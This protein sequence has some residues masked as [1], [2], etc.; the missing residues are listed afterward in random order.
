MFISDYYDLLTGERS[1]MVYEDAEK[2]YAEVRKEGKALLEDAFGALL[3]SSTRLSVSPDEPQAAAVS[4]RECNIVAFNTTMFP[5]LDVVTVPLTGNGG[6]KLKT[7]VIQTSAD[8]KFGYALMHGT[9]GFGL[10]RS[11]GLFADCDTPSGMPCERFYFKDEIDTHYSLY[12]L[13]CIQHTLATSY[14]VILLFN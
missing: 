2:L 8:G 9:D 10:A 4:S 13:K 7:K 12:Y 3:K 6:P 14:W 11:R 5:R 1:G